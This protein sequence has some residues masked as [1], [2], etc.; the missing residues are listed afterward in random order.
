MDREKK[1][2]SEDNQRKCLINLIGILMIQIKP[3]IAYLCY[4][5]MIKNDWNMNMEN[6]RKN[7]IGP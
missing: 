2:I 5:K 3:I 1:A 4:L 6:N 7:L